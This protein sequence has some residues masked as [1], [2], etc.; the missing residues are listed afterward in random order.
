M[1][2]PTPTNLIGRWVTFLIER[3]AAGVTLK[4]GEDDA[5]DGQIL[6]KLVGNGNRILAGHGVSN[7]KDLGRRHRLLDPDQLAHQFHI[8]MESAGGIDKNRVQPF[9]LGSLN[10][11]ATDIHRVLGGLGRMHRHPDLFAQHF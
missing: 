9:G 8:D 11:L 1:P 2:S 3:A 4:L 7:E 10:R 5:T 6:I